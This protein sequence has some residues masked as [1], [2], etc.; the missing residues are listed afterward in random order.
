MLYNIIMMISCYMKVLTGEFF[1]VIMTY[2]QRNN[3]C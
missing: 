3:V 1:V 2:S